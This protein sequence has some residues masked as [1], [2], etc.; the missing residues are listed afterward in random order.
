MIP[1]CAAP[2]RFISALG[3]GRKRVVGRLGL[4]QQ[5]SFLATNVHQFGLS[6][7]FSS[8]APLLYESEHTNA[9]HTKPLQ[10]ILSVSAIPLIGARDAVWWTGR[11]PSRC[12]GVGANGELYSL[13][14]LSLDGLSR[15][16][17][18]DYFDNTWA[19]T[20]VLLA[21]L[22]GESAFTCPPYHDLRHPMIFYYGHP[23]ALYVNKLRVAGLLKDPINPYFEVIFETGVDEMS[24]DDLSRNA[25]TWP[26]VAEVH[27]YRKKVYVAVS[28]VISNISEEQLAKGIGK[29]DPLWSL[30]MGFEHERIHLETSSVLISEMPVHLTRF[31]EGFPSYHE[32][33]EKDPSE[34]PIRHPVAGIHYPTSEMIAV[35]QQKITLGKPSDYPSF[36]WDNEYGSRSYDLPAFKASKFKTTNGEY[37]EFVRDGGYSNAE[38]WSDAGWKWR[39]FRNVKWPCYWVI[40]GP[41]GLNHFSLRLLFNV[42]PMAWDLPVCV[43]MH[44]A[45]AYANWK[46]MN[47]DSNQSYRVISE[48][49]HHAIRDE[50]QRP[51]SKDSV[52]LVVHGPGQGKLL[53]E[54]NTNFNLSCSSMNSVT[55]LPS[56]ERGFH[57]VFGNA[58]DWTT[59]LFSA[60]KGFEVHPYY[61]DFSTP[62]FD[63]L[64][65]I[66]MGGSFMSTG[67]V[68]LSSL[69]YS[70]YYNFLM[71][72]DRRID[73]VRPLCCT[74]YFKKHPL[75]SSQAMRAQSTVD[76]I[77]D[78]ISFSMLQ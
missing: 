71:Y 41:Q 3:K 18:Q 10:S 53:T 46:S 68:Y 20:E 44:E 77:S 33:V 6:Q 26:S 75:F 2:K 48:L 49:E 62:C 22:Q 59:S 19:L 42:V 17:I 34:Q 43:N 60:L 28:E 50:S 4:L 7:K 24:W 25:M 61:E 58:W 38:L 39:S 27:T 36:G 12:A 72:F 64:H 5:E 69:L 11:H 32:S 76:F 16:K 51:S 54:R 67:S 74:F 15:K 37:W 14:Q 8:A 23:A 78:L 13:P 52:D 9:P 66:I 56:N 63:G 73:F 57:D 70:I 45:T 65:H 47:S 21:S 35:E 1:I 29:S 40:D 31:P 55:A 30:V